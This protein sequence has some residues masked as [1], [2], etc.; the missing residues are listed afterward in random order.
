MTDVMKRLFDRLPDKSELPMW[1]SFLQSIALL[2]IAMTAALYSTAA[3]RTGDMIP[4][5]TTALI[6]LVIAAWVGARLV[7]RLARGV[8]WTWLPSLNQIKITRD[9]GIFF[10]TL[11]VVLLAAINTSNNLLYMV[12]SALV[13]VLVLSLLLSTANF[14]YL[15][16]QL[17]LPSRT[18]AREPF[19]LSVRIHNT[20]RLFPAFSLFME[21]Q[22]AS[23]YFQVIPPRE[24]AVRSAETHFEQRGRHSFEKLKAQSR[25]PF[26]FFYKSH[27]YD[28]A[29]ECICYPEILPLDQLQL[30]VADIL[31]ANQRMERGVGNDLHSIR[32]YVASDSA[33]HVHWKA[34]AKTASLKTREFANEDSRHIELAFDRYGEPKDR[35]QFEALVS[36]A[37]SI[38]FHLAKEGAQAILI[39]DDWESPSGGGEN[40]LDAILR[41][42]AFVEMSTTA[43]PPK[44]DQHSGTILFSL[45][46]GRRHSR[47]A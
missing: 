30:S 41:Y 26:G 13:A 14:K 38:A 32:Q 15:K 22:D 21:P 3:A 27:H 18:F 37:A 34:S 40:T 39:S 47:S 23:L 19:S 44:F 4:A 5:V 11:V 42:L 35:E 29:T 16:V 9:G 20:R 33:R 17:I 10:G 24:T 25:F 45:R 36:H 46:E 31:G 28:I 8:D 1:K 43:T 2:A 6:S 7:P 12:L